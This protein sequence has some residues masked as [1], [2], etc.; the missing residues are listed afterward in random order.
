[1]YS[2]SAARINLDLNPPTEQLEKVTEAQID[3]RRAT[4]KPL[5][6]QV[7]KDITVL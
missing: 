7:V 6:G 3:E 4:L 1:M 2:L 5:R